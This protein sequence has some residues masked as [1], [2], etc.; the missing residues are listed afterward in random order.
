MLTFRP[1]RPMSEK[2]QA[3]AIED[4]EQGQPIDAELTE[5]DFESNKLETE[6][7][8]EA[9]A[10]ESDESDKDNKE[11]TNFISKKGPVPNHGPDWG[12]ASLDIRELMALMVVEGSDDRESIWKIRDEQT[13]QTF[14]NRFQR[15]IVSENSLV[16]H[17]IPLPLDAAGRGL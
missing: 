15:K 5:S 13:S 16:E 3:L 4:P 14:D 6:N 9:S 10:E 1:V 7:I 12:K 2:K 11:T 17:L 8:Y